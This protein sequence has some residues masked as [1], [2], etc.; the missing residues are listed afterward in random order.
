MRASR[1]L[2]VLAALAATSAPALAGT[3]SLIVGPTQMQ[4]TGV[5]TQY[6]SLG[7]AG[8][9]GGVAHFTLPSDFKKNSTATLRLTLAN[10]GVNCS[11]RF[12]FDRVDRWRTGVVP[13]SGAPGAIG[14]SGGAT[15]DV[16]LGPNQTIVKSYEVK[17]MTT[18]PIRGQRKG[19]TVSIVFER[20]G[21]NGSDTCGNILVISGELRYKTP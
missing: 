8:F 7:D 20:D 14:V 2:A 21:D 13:I 16:A 11:M 1:Y 10:P 19:D 6:L 9:T 12:G 17:G 5:N 4:G 3:R 15:K 18:G